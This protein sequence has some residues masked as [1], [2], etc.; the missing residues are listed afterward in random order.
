MNSDRKYLRKSSVAIIAGCLLGACSAGDNQ[1]L[2]SVNPA[3][4]TSGATSSVVATSGSSALR[5]GNAVSAIYQQT[6]ADTVTFD[7]LGI[8]IAAI[9]GGTVS[10]SLADGAS[11]LLGKTVIPGQIS[12]LPNTSNSDFSTQSLATNTD[13]D[14][15][16][17]G[18]LYAAFL[19]G[20]AGT[21]EAIDVAIDAL[22]EGDVTNPIGGNLLDPADVNL[23]LLPGAES[24]FW[25]F[26][27]HACG[28]TRTD[29]LHFDD[30]NTGYLGC[31]TSSSGGR[32]LFQTEDGGLT[33]NPV[34]DPDGF[35]DGMRINTISRS[36]DGL[37]YVGGE[38]GGFN[39][40]SVDTD[41]GNSVA[42]VFTT[43][44]TVGFSFSVGTFRR[45]STG[46]AIAES[47]TGADL[48]FRESDS[49]DAQGSWQDGSNWNEPFRPSSRFQILDMVLYRDQFYGSGSTIS[50]PNFVFLP[51]QVP[52]GGVE[53]VPVALSPESGIGAFDGELWGIAV[54]DD[55][56][57]AGGVDQSN[58][59]GVVYASNDDPYN[60]SDWT[61]YK[62][63]TLFDREDSTWVEG[64]C[65]SSEQIV[66][67]GRFSRRD[68]GI[69]LVSKD[70]AQTFED[71]TP[72]L[73]GNPPREIPA[74]YECETFDN[75]DI[76][77]GGAGG[78]VGVYT[79]QQ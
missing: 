62:L 6:D 39:V 45:N 40:V 64:V 61:Q 13:L 33:W 58:G 54:N 67:V 68:T 25:T 17:A 75:G 18:V 50:E 14:L 71:I 72:M 74:L 15:L 47:L 69:V 77:V 53:F 41:N 35:L 2:T 26:A 12:I 57:V 49:N 43:R 38:A 19:L 70:N 79:P 76:V 9:Q 24:Q 27:S 73:P 28:S 52:Q 7:D 21:P 32:G 11:T 65:R 44:P 37:L 22:L 66:A 16:D 10:Q 60:A 20:D 59:I 56:I 51:P 4:S 1:P 23:S 63:S 3:R 55:G 36:S 8:L 78:F 42:E 31:G 48:V 34:S 30:R 29:D 46:F 5:T